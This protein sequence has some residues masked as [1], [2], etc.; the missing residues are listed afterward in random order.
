MA[1]PGEYRQDSLVLTGR[2]VPHDDSVNDRAEGS[3]LTT[4]SDDT[5][6]EWM[7]LYGTPW[8]RPGGMWCGA[9]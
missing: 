7:R 9:F 2:V 1:F 3:K 6:Q 4:C 8:A 5:R